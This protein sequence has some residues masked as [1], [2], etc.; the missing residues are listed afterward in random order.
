MFGA[1][2]KELIADGFRGA[3]DVDLKDYAAARGLD[4]RGNTTQLG[5]MA[6]MPMSEELQF[7]VLRGTLAGGEE[8]I[9]FHEAKMYEE[10]TPGTFYGQRVG[11]KIKWGDMV[12]KPKDLL[13][14]LPGA[15][16]LSGGKVHYFK[17]PTTT[18]AIRLPE[19]QGPLVGLQVGRKNERVIQGGGA[20]A[21]IEISFRDDEPRDTGPGHWGGNEL[22][23]LGMPGWRAAVRMRGRR[24][25]QQAVLAGP[26]KELLSAEQPLGFQVTFWFGTLIVLQQHFL[27]EPPQLDALSEKCSWL[28]KEVRRICV[29][30]GEPLP[31]ETAL[32]EP[33]WYE[34]WKTVPQDKFYGGNGENLGSA[35]QVAAERGMA[36][37]DQWAFQRGFCDLGVPGEPFGVLRGVLPGTNLEGRVVGTLGRVAGMPMDLDK[38]LEKPIGGPFGHDVVLL[39]VR[40]DTPD[41]SYRGEQFGEKGRW[42][43]RRGVLVTWRPRPGSFMTT[44]EV[45][46]AVAETVALANEKGLLA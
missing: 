40:P 36:V 3:P 37:E 17:C 9:L 8:G 31:F 16:L 14:M 39:P 13:Y 27:K 30:M 23:E 15:G 24:E 41:G 12:P 18:V 7:N 33:G 35:A 25:V 20:K 38:A 11:G 28:A 6:A 34:H 2:T 44:H 32:P 5:V 42:T 19:A 4:H 46:A 29:A 45:D 22:D 43:V 21:L 26:V 1:G 10:G